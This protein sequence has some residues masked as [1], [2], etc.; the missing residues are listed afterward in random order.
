VLLVLVFRQISWTMPIVQALLSLVSELRMAI[1]HI[2]FDEQ[3]PFQLMN[4]IAG[5]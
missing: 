4:I 2:L 5:T 3:H 1:E